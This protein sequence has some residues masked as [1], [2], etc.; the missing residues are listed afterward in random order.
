M[1][2]ITLS[3]LCLA[4]SGLFNHVSAQDYKVAVGIRFSTAAPTVSN[5]LSLKYFLDETSAVEGLMSF[6]SRFALGALYEKHQIIGGTP[7]FT[8]FYGVG[9]Y[10][11]F[12]NHTTYL[13]P[14]GITGLDYKFQNAPLNLSLDWKPELDII[15]KINFVPSAFAFTARFTF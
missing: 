10:I 4:F 7:A 14:Q 1:R 2:V 9:G 15:P 3:L 6:G 11:G 8:W 12:E 13:G 5:S